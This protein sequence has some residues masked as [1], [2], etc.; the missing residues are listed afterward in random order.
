M[1]TIIKYIDS[2][3]EHGIESIITIVVTILFLLVLNRIINKLIKKR[4]QD[5]L[6]IAIRVKR[7][8]LYTIAL[9]VIF[10][11]INALKSIVT[12]LLAS[13]GI[14]AVVIGLASQEAASN[15]INGIMI[16]TYKPYTVGD[17][18]NIPEHNVK[19]KVIDI[20]LRHTIMET[21]EKTQIIIPN[22]LMNKAVIENIS[23]VPNKKANYLYIDISYESDVNKA[24]AIIQKE[25]K[26]HP[27]FVDPR[28]TIEKE[29]QI[30]SVPV[31]CIDF[32]ESAVGLRATVTSLD[33]ANGFIM[34]SDLRLSIKEAF[35]QE[36]ITIPYP[37]TVIVNK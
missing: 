24:I 19:G 9:S 23:N 29:E 13:G 25:T 1:D 16:F 37:H 7:V 18:I 30:E 34:L 33:N 6:Y 21:L 22:T 36:G 27:L 3:F 35:E 15:I 5:S 14:I 4:W 20:A 32:K 12:A 2:I 17:F 8:I 10:M 26:K 28:S 31:Y 11:Q